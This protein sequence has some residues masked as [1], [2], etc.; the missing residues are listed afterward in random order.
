[1]RLVLFLSRR[2]ATEY[3]HPRTHAQHG[4]KRPTKH[5]PIAGGETALT[6]PTR[7]SRAGC[8]RTAETCSGILSGARRSPAGFQR[9]RRL[10]YA[11]RPSPD[12]HADIDG[13]E[14]PPRQRS[15]EHV[16]F[17]VGDGHK[18]LARPIDASHRRHRYT[19]SPLTGGKTDC[20]KYVEEQEVQFVASN[21]L[22]W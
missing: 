21:S 22:A 5:R 11:V 18:R 20:R 2:R 15:R 12:C 17:T 1:M 10:P 16:G 8:G 19:D 9:W 6:T 4:A 13:E 7:F 14:I 3:L